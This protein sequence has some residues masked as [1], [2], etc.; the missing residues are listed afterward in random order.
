M[1]NVHVTTIQSLKKAHDTGQTPTLLDEG[2]GPMCPFRSP[3]GEG[4]KIGL[5][6]TNLKGYK[7][8]WFIEEIKDQLVW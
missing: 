7:I 5:N 6:M 4:Q 1:E 8:K 3:E 2:F